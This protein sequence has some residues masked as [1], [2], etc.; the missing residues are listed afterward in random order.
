MLPNKSLFLAVM[1]LATLVSW[2]AV[3]EIPMYLSHQGRLLNDDFSPVAGIETVTFSLYEYAD[4]GVSVWSEPN[5]IALDNGFYSVVLGTSVSISEDLFDGGNIYLGIK[6]GSD[7]ELSP[8]QRITSVPFAI[9][10]GVAEKVVGSVNASDGLWVGDTQVINVDGDWVGSP[11]NVQGPQGDAGPSGDPGE[12]GPPGE[13]GPQGDAGPQGIQGEPGPP[14]E[15]G[16]PGEQ[17]PPGESGSG[18]GGGMLA[19]QFEFDA[20]GTPEEFEDSSGLENH[21][22]P[23][24]GLSGGSAGH[25][26]YAVDFSGGIVTVPEGNSIPDSAQIWVEAWIKPDFPLD[27]VGERVIFEKAGAYTIKQIDN[28]VQFEVIGQRDPYNCEI[29]ASIAGHAGVWTHV[30]GWYNGLAVGVEIDG[31]TSSLGCDIGPFARTLGEPFYVG[32]TLD[33][34][35]GNRTRAFHGTIDEVR[36]RLTAPAGHA[37]GGSWWYGMGPCRGMEVDGICVTGHRYNS[38]GFYSASN[39]CADRNSDLC[40]DSQMTILLRERLMRQASWTNSYADND[41]GQWNVA[42]GGTGDNH[43]ENTA[44]GVA[45]CANSVPPSEIAYQAEDVG[46]VKVTWVANEEVYYWEQAA[47]ACAALRSDICSKSQISV[48]RN[49]SSI[50]V[51][52]WSND[53][54]DNDGGEW[55]SI[56]GGTSND[57]TNNQVYGFACC[58]GTRPADGSCP[59]TDVNGVCMSKAVNSGVNFTTA[60]A[61]CASEGVDICSMSESY[62]L[63]QAGRITYGDNWTDSGSDVDSNNAPN[64]VGSGQHDN[65]SINNS[66]GYACCY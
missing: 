1:L 15:Q 38:S 50:S 45:C 23:S 10:A 14:G 2:S 3:A 24:G 9:R 52:V 60:A 64:A 35:S 42:N 34:N 56:V 55:N 59:G 4:G 26:V 41:S 46:G 16:S 19:I 7:T 48:L 31:Y 39:W 12:Q 18:G 29:S 30:A 13:T 22:T 47:S 54:S 5:T 21:A 65:A 28:T 25:T 43:A 44:Y 11:S 58:A 36:V 57:T 62:V 8:R 61:D 27:G 37:Y 17:G 51:R 33:P 20:D 49:N 32:A 63:R 53:H 6:I 40:S 66:W